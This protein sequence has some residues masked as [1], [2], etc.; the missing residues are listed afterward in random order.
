MIKYQL[1][2]F[3][4]SGQ[5]LT[6]QSSVVIIICE[7]SIDV[8][9]TVHIEV[10]C[11]TLSMKIGI[12]LKV[13]QHDCVY[14]MYSIYISKLLQMIDLYLLYIYLYLFLNTIKLMTRNCP[15]QVYLSAHSPLSSIALCNSAH[16][17]PSFHPNVNDKY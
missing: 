9:N 7:L 17:N 12:R 8:I 5:L 3:H 6:L 4:F 15:W 11:Q 2:D 1:I 14:V 16:Q 13:Q 10:C